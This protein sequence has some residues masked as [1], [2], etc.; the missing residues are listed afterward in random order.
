MNCSDKDYIKREI[1]KGET[2][3]FAVLPTLLKEYGKFSYNRYSMWLDNNSIIDGYYSR[4][5]YHIE[6]F[7]LKD[8]KVYVKVFWQLDN[9]DGEE[10]VE[11]HEL[12][13]IKVTIN[14]TTHFYIYSFDIY[15]AIKNLEF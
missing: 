13:D 3:A 5:D 11:L 1:E 4:I 12:K 2:N 14:P 9:A 6:G 7:V 10:L 15:H 8:N